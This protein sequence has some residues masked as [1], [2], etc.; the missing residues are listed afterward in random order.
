[1]A[2]PEVSLR[3]TSVEFY[4]LQRG[5]QDAAEFVEDELILTGDEEFAIRGDLS[6]RLDLY[7][8]LLKRLQ[9]V[10]REELITH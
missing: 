10:E 6:Q 4:A 1:M 7:N 9:R 3:L 2:L 8:R 5:L